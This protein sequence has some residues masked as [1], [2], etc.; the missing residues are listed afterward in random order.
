MKRKINC[1]EF[2]NCGMEPGGIF[3]KIYGECPVPEMMKFDGQNGG[4]GAGR[5]CW[6][7]MHNGSGIGPFVCRNRR[8]SCVQCEF[9]QRVQIEESRLDE[10]EI[11]EK[12]HSGHKISIQ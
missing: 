12:S 7:V 9:F 5:A 11:S 1:W 6:M 8:V 4:T 10:Y 3:S 2:R